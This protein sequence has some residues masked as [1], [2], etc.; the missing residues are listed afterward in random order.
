[1]GSARADDARSRLIDLVSTK[2]QTGPERIA[3]TTVIGQAIDV[4]DVRLQSGPVRGLIRP[5]EAP[6]APAQ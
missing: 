5:P 3:E 1:M 6:T 4:I 2:R